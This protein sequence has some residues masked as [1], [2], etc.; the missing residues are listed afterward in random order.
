MQ[1]QALRQPITTEQYRSEGLVKTRSKKPAFT[2]L[3]LQ[4]LVINILNDQSQ[5]LLVRQN[6]Y[7]PEVH[8]EYHGWNEMQ[9]VIPP[10]G[11]FLGIKE[12][13]Q[14]RERNK[15]QRKKTTR[16]EQKRPMNQ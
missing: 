9:E 3:G 1:Y 16:S 11:S 14:K 4:V 2:Q 5:F 10:P 12:H 15:Q 7:R 8:Q 13:I 6:E